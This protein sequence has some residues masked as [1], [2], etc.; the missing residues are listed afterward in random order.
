MKAIQ[1]LREKNIK[2]EFYPDLAVSNKATKTT[3]EIRY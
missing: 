2:C 1:A 3:M